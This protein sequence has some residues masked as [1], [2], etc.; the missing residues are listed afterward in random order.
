L[1][2][3]EA[4]RGGKIKKGDHVLIVGFGA[5]MTWGSMVVKW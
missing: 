2:L 3:G 5:G 4:V 1:A